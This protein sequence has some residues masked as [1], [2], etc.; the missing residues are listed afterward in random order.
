MEAALNG[1]NVT[2]SELKDLMVTVVRSQEHIA[3]LQQGHID[4]EKRLRRI[5]H[6][7]ATGKWVERVVWILVSTGLVGLFKFVGGDK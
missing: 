6:T 1:I 3:S 5:E 2:L 7:Q 4:Q